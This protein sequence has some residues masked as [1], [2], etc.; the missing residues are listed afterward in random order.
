M[1]IHF[2]E[3][4]LHLTVFCQ[5]IFIIMK[6]FVATLCAVLLVANCMNLE[7]ASKRGLQRCRANRDCGDSHCCL[8]GFLCS[9]YLSEGSVCVAGS[10]FACG[11]APGFSCEREEGWNWWRAPKKVAERDQMTRNRFVGE[12]KKN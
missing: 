9:P 5:D 6:L 11:C 4:S 12:E 1:G 2:R 8:G 7:D 10:T 3:P